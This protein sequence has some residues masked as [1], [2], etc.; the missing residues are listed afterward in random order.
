MCLGVIKLDNCKVVVCFVE[1]WV[2]VL[3]ELGYIVLLII[4][5]K[6]LKDVVIL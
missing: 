5:L 6:Y 4:D 3:L 1:L 2:W